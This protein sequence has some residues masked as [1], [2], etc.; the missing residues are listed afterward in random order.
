MITGARA[1]P[2][3]GDDANSTLEFKMG[4]VRVKVRITNGMD[5]MRV[6]AGELKSED[7][8]TFEGEAL[9]DSGTVKTVIP[10]SVMQQLGI[11]I[12]SERPVRYADGRI[13]TVPVTGTIRVHIQNRDA[14]DEAYVLGDEILVG[15]TVLECMDLHIDCNNRKLIPNPKYPDR[16]V[17]RV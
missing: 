1:A 15:Q 9:V 13:E 6:K 3:H 5:E 4:E 12:M 2:A 8:R 16:P 10:A 14:I 7:V 17:L 11:P